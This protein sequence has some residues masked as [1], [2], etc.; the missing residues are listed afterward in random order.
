MPKS[1]KVERGVTDITNNFQYNNAGSSNSQSDDR[2]QLVTDD[3]KTRSDSTKF[4]QSTNK[5]T[6]PDFQKTYQ[7]TPDKPLEL[8]I[9]IS[10]EDISKVKV[11]VINYANRS[12]LR[13]KWIPI[14]E[15]IMPD[16]TVIGSSGEVLWSPQKERK[17]ADENR[18]DRGNRK[19]MRKLSDTS[20]SG[21]STKSTEEEEEQGQREKKK[22]RKWTDASST[23]GS[24]AESAEEKEEVGPGN[25]RKRKW[26]DS[27]SSSGSSAKSTE[28]AE[29]SGGS[30]SEDGS[31]TTTRYGNSEDGTCVSPSISEDS[32]DSI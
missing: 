31:S 30:S 10:P 13:Q 26:S 21:S 4:R 15:K 24:S 27:S 12:E 32:T 16:G 1:T 3:D 7:L 8:R 11:Q 22:V 9:K 6:T 5:N 18:L 28:E 19:R 14:S 29:A 25:K 2:T 23:G 20:S 17:L